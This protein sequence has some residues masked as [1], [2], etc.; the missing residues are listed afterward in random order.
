MKYLMYEDAITHRF[1]FLP[2]PKRF[3]DGDA[4]PAVTIDRW[5]DSHADAIAAL[6]E[7]FTRDEPSDARAEV[8]A[9]PSAIV[10][11]VDPRRP[12]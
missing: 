7:L 2:L 1:A 6:S 5:F 4:L 10:T 11:L 12:H 9:P 8:P 3:A